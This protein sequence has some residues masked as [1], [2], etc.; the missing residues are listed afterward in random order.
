MLD[1]VGTMQKNLRY[2]ISSPQGVGKLHKM[3]LNLIDTVL[4]KGT[5]K[6]VVICPTIKR[7]EACRKR[8]IDMLNND[9]NIEVCFYSTIG[10]I[11][12]TE[13]WSIRFISTEDII[14]VESKIAGIHPDP[15]RFVDHSVEENI[16]ATGL[17]KI[18]QDI[19]FMRGDT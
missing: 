7:A 18:E 11:N 5:G 17:D 2:F 3:L 9:Q 13:G 1:Y 16:I 15:L 4:H 10:E 12:V 19:K 8:V 14:S 6:F